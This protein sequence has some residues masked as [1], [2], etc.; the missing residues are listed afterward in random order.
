[1]TQTWL[2]G[3]VETACNSLLALDTEV[4]A[5][6]DELSD[7]VIAVDIT[8]LNIQLYFFPSAQG[9][10]VLSHYEGEPDTWLRGVPLSL[11]RLALSD[12]PADELFAGGI[13][14]HGD[15]QTGQH[16]QD[17]LRRLDLDW[18][19][20]LARVAGDDVAHQ[21]GRVMQGARAQGNHVRRSLELNVG[22]YLHEEAG[23]LVSH[24]ELDAF[25]RDVDVL[26]SDGERLDARLRRLEA[27]LRTNK[28]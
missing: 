25:L 15:T 21:A 9:M 1:M 6:L 16:F 23:L 17:I 19:E 28:D 24:A 8:G 27:A 12:K 26:N 5:Q 3:T 2:A 22:E 4:R 18:E 10:Q 14:L 11:L 20:L 13:E 7:K